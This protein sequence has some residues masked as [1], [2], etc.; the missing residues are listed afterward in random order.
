LGL[1]VVGVLSVVGV[2]AGCFVLF[3]VHA[4]DVSVD[5]LYDV[6]LTP[7][8]PS[9][10]PLALARGK[11]LVESVGAC[12]GKDCHG[13]DLGGGR[14]LEIG[15]L[16]TFT[17]PN[18]TPSGALAV[19][20]DA[21]LFRLLRHG[22]K[23]DGRTVLFMP[24]QDFAWLSDAD[25]AAEISY[26]RTT[27]SV[28]RPKGVMHVKTL[29][30]IVDRKDGIIL[31][32][33]RRIP[34]DK[35][36]LAPPPAETKEYGQYVGRLCTG[37]HGEHLSGGPI[38][39]APSSFAVPLNLTPDATGLKGWSY[40]DLDKLLTLGLQKN[41]ARIGPLMPLENFSNFDDTEKRALYA[42]LMSL[43]PRPFGGR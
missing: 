15:P 10:E 27:A 17:A 16:A 33:A 2:V 9:T 25:I 36:D 12:T 26:L 41:G 40:E 35:P 38:P 11:H 19:Y 5:K 23:R 42:Y 6:P 30:K 18:I 1:A 20:S 32:V 29:G 13:K 22:V 3:L 37:C 31:D 21:E 39:G 7:V 8:R 24:V 43:P 28:E 4:F 34:H 14:P